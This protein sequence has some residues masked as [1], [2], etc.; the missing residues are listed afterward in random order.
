MQISCVSSGCSPPDLAFLDGS[1]LYLSWLQWLQN[2]FPTP[3]LCLH[4][5]FGLYNKQELSFPP[6]LFIICLSVY[7]WYGFLPFSMAYNSLL[8]LIT[9]VLTWPQFWPR[10]V[11]PADS[12]AL[13]T[14]CLRFFGHSLYFTTQNVSGWYY[15]FLLLEP[16]IFVRNFGIRNQ[17][18]RVVCADWVWS[19]FACWLSQLSK[20]GGNTQDKHVYIPVRAHGYT[21]TCTHSILVM[22]MH[23]LVCMCSYI[24]L[25]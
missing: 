8:T 7:H 21:S 20:L 24:Y 23:T 12:C 22:H 1:G 15:N 16:A 13:L 9:F 17:N 19:V 6:H 2:D 18:L 4:L 25:P 11:L 3:P 5:L 14:C 10:R